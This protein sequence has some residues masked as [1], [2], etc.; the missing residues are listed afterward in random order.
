MHSKCYPVWLFVAFV[1]KWRFSTSNTFDMHTFICRMTWNEDIYR[2]NGEKQV[3]KVTKWTANYKKKNYHDDS[4]AKEN[5]QTKD[6]G[7]F[8]Y[9]SY[10]RL[11]PQWSFVN[12]N[13][14]EKMKKERL[15]SPHI[16]CI[17]TYTHDLS[18]E[19]GT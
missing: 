4:N 14:T 6:K 18:N 12:I 15:H 11:L 3:A 2:L 13:I 7:H 19:W 1:I 5:A 9:L 16:Q 8:N 10:E 17:H